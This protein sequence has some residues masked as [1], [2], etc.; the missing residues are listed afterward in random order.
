M[1]DIN[2]L[3]EETWKGLGKPI[4]WPPTF[5]LVDVDQHGIKPIK[6]LMAQWVMIGTHPF[7]WNSMVIPLKRKGYDIILKRGWLLQVRLNHD[8]NR[9]I[10]S[11]ERSG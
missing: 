1:F 11:M 2:I 7:I 4:L 9:N 8:W 10:F 6:T 3:L 5:Q